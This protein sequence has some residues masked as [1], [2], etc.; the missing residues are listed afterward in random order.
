M[1]MELEI[2]LRL[3]ITLAWLGVLFLWSMAVLKRPTNKEDDA[4]E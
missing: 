3:A 4:S 1:R 2:G